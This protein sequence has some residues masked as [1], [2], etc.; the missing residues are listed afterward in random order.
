MAVPQKEQFP[1]TSGG[2]KATTLPHPLHVTCSALAVMGCMRFPAAASL[3]SCATTFEP[4][5]R[6]CVCPQCAHFS[7]PVSG[8]NCIPAPQLGQANCSF[9]AA[10]GIT[11]GCD[12][13]ST[14]IREAIGK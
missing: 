8:L 3:K 10:S 1:A 9:T 2:S 5:I 6:A 11:F 4:A 14:D 12:P 13:G 7:W